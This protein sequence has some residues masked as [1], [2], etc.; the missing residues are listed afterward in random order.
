MRKLFPIALGPVMIVRGVRFNSSSSKGP[1]EDNVNLM[2]SNEVTPK[3]TG[4]FKPNIDLDRN[5]TL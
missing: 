2:D 5:P 3:V 1:Y 4:T